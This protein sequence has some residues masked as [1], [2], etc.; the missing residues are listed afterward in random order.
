MAGLLTQH[1]V[2]ALNAHVS[3]ADPE[4]ERA[5][6]R[7]ISNGCVLADSLSEES[8]KELCSVA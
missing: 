2:R 4:A 8:V 1:A 3:S 5:R 6:L 7:P